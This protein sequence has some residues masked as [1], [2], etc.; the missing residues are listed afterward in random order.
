MTY[1]TGAVAGT[2]IK[3]R[4]QFNDKAMRTQPPGTWQGPV[5][6]SKPGAGG[7]WYAPVPEYE[8]FVD[9]V[10][11]D[12]KTQDK[13]WRHLTL[14]TDRQRQAWEMVIET[15]S[16]GSGRAV[17]RV[18]GSQGELLARVSRRRGSIFR[19]AR[20]S[21]RVEPANGPELRARKGHLVA[22]FFWWLFSPLWAVMLALILVGGEFPR[23][24]LTTRWRR[25]GHE[26]MHFEDG[27][28]L[29]ASDWPDA[30]L[31]YAVTMLHWAHPTVL[32]DWSR[33]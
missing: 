23:M 28:Y 2:L 21:W 29:V 11:R 3:V 26:V 7:D 32:S 33:P 1:V 16:S 18:L 8:L 6:M 13:D 31:I 5:L 22:W 25:D 15:E 9:D 17:Y 12:K 19:L 24:P 14:W 27:K 10:P 30:R 20:T 4:G